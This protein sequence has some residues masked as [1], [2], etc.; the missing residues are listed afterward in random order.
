LSS[1]KPDQIET[2]EQELE[3]PLT[4]MDQ[5]LASGVHIGTRQKTGDMDSHVYRVRSDGLF[6]LDVREADDRIRAAASLISNYPPEKVYAVSARQYGQ[7]PVEKFGEVT[8][9]KTRAGRFIPGTLTNPS[10]DGYIEPELIIMTDPVADEQPLREAATIGIPVIG[11]CDSDNETRNIDLVIPANNR[12]RKALALVYYL[13][14]RQVLVERGEL[15]EDEEWDVTL[16]EFE[17]QFV[18]EEQS[19]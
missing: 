19:Q 18:E 8:G 12:G 10:Y 3:E 1:D 7:R 4:D 5:Y 9:V 11:I 15:E 6:V 13:L 14:A 17:A 2:E 16:E